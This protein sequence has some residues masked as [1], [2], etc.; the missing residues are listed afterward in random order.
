MKTQPL[1]FHEIAENLIALYRYAHNAGGSI[2][3]DTLD[4]IV[5]LAADALGPARVAELKKAIDDSDASERRDAAHARVVA[6]L[7]P[8]PTSTEV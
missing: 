3:F 7:T 4:M 5:A 8:T 6:D 2:D 1:A